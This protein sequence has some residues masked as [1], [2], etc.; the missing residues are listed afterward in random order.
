MLRIQPDKSGVNLETEANLNMRIQ[1]ETCGL[2]RE[3]CA[4][5]RGKP[6][7]QWIQCIAQS[8]KLNVS[9]LHT[10][11]IS[12]PLNL[13]LARSLSLSRKLRKLLF[14]LLE[15]CFLFPNKPSVIVPEKFNG[16]LRASR[17]EGDLGEGE[18]AT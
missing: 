2:N 11:T 13:S 15:N 6:S 4:G 8:F 5:A 17:C 7:R 16:V 3:Q 1:T 10:H 14:V 12:L 9:H 18:E